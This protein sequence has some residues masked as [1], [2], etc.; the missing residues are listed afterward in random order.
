MRASP[1]LGIVEPH[2]AYE[3]VRVE[4]IGRHPELLG[5]MVLEQAVDEDDVAADELLAARHPLAGDEPM[6]GDEF[7]VQPGHPH[8]GVA[9]ARRCLADIADPALEGEVAALDDVL[10][11]RPI[12]RRGRHPDE[13]GVALEL[14]ELE[15]R[16]Q[17]GDHGVDEV[18]EDVLRVVE[19]HTGEIAAVA[20]DVG[21]DE[22]GWIGPGEHRADPISRAR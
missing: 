19:L 22:A 6:V 9:L 8:A 13:C 2:R 14:R 7:Q 20:C 16:T 10:K 21:D 11:G 15:R 17:R 12:D 5:D 4:G 3:D 18:G 1:L